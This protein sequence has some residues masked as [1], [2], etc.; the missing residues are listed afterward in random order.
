MFYF[1][2]GSDDDDYGYMYCEWDENPA[3]N[4][5]SSPPRDD[6]QR[7]RTPGARRGDR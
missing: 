7:R 1:D 2:T 3:L 6:D 4:K 5:M